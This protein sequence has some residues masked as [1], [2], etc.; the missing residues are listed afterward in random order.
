M[1]DFRAIYHMSP[2]ETASIPSREYL[3]LAF[4][5]PAFQGV[6]AYRISEAE[7]ERKKPR[8]KTEREA[9]ERDPILSDVIS[10]S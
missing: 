8:V 9:I 6:M 10:F 1:A 2:Q 7:A 3:A 4:R 5:L